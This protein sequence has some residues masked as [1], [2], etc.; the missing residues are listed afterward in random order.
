MYVVDVRFRLEG[1]LIPVDHGYLLLSAIAQQL[2]ELHGNDEVGIHPISGRLAGNRCL[3]I[4]EQSFL[5]LRVSTDRIAGI[6]PLAGKLLSLGEHGVRIGVPQTRTLIP[7]ARLY[8]RIVVIKGFTLPE[9]FLAAAGRQLQDM[10]IRGNPTLVEQSHIAQTN[11]D[12]KSGTHSPFLRRTIQIHDKQIVGF[13][14]RVGELT[15]EESIR[16]Q[17]KGL[18]GRR[19]FGCGIFIPDRR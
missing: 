9:K 13:A 8:S 12:K 17:E 18:G 1:N 11:V 6:L 7:S 16:L 15:A 14:L 2:P 3:A 4:T 19:R 5:T 10:E